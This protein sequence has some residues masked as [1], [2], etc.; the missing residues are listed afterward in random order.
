MA[1]QSL[2]V[3]HVI[4]WAWQCDVSSAVHPQFGG[5]TPESSPGAG[6]GELGGAE[7]PPLPKLAVPASPGGVAMPPLHQH[8]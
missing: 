8:C 7:P 2:A 4:I 6:E 3:A 1:G 5:E